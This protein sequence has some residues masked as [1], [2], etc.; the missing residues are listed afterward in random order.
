MRV[1]H[2]AL[3]TAILT[4]YGFNARNDLLPNSSP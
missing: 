4:A 2:V 1:T 3:D